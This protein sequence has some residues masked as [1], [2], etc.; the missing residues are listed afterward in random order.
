MSV[1]EISQNGRRPQETGA[2]P[3]HDIEMEKAVLGSMMLSASALSDCLELLLPWPGADLF[4]REAHKMI[5]EAIVALDSDSQPV[6]PLTVKAELER[7]EQ[8]KVCGTADYLHTLIAAVPAPAA[9]AFYTRKL[10][11]LDDCPQPAARRPP[12]RPD[13]RVHRR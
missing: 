5:F 6:D 12:H 10:L 9:A 11:K 4:F 1:V 8:L 2:L 13:G 3:P 7:R